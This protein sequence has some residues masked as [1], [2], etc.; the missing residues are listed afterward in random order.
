MVARSRR[1]RKDTPPIQVDGA[2]MPPLGMAPI[3]FGLLI[4]A[5]WGLY[6]TIRGR[7]L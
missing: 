2:G 7:W 5:P 1:A 4:G 3:V 6:A